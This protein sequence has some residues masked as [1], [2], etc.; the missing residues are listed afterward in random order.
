MCVCV[1]LD[2]YSERIVPTEKHEG[3]S[4]RI[5][6]CMSAKGVGEM[7]CLDGT[8]NTCGY[9]KILAAKMTPSLW[10][11]GIFQH[12]NDPKH[13]AKITVCHLNFNL[14]EFERGM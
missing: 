2:Y 5:W 9:T 1:C 13:T 11:L 6:D 14:I 8:M 10:K 4:V 12:D 7:T 3:G